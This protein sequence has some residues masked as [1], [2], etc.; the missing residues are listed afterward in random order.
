[1]NRKRYFYDNNL[2]MLLKDVVNT[3]KDYFPN[4][5]IDNVKVVVCRNCKSKALAR[6]YM[7]PPVWRFVL[8]LEPMYVIE[9][10]E[11]N[12]SLLTQSEK[13]KVFIHELLHIPKN[14][15]GGLRPHGKYVNSYLVDKLYKEYVKRKA[16]VT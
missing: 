4:I 13:I 14:F 1:M 8:G 16:C 7:L 5:K 9:V 2:E 12:F 15:S 6:I 3:L 11:K 10:I